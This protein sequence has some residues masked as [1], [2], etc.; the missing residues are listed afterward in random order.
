[1]VQLMIAVF[2]G[3]FDVHSVF[4]DV[5]EECEKTKY[6]S[7]VITPISFDR[8]TLAQRDGPCKVHC[9]VRK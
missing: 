1:M 3:M 5:K 2:F 7:N 6:S 8:A 9:R 4:S